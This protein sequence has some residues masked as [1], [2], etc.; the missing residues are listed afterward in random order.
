MKASSC[1]GETTAK[2]A[3]KLIRKG[4]KN[5]ASS[6]TQDVAQGTVSTGE[7]HEHKTE[8]VPSLLQILQWRFLGAGGGNRIV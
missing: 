4:S 6:P 2:S 1:Q 8:D 7:T 5:H 3:N